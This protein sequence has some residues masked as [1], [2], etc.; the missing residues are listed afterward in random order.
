MDN[1]KI[2]MYEELQDLVHAT[3]ALVFFLLPYSPDLN[4]IEVGVSLLKRWIQRY[5]NMAFREVPLG[6]LKVAM[7]QC[8]R[9]KELVGENLYSHCGYQVNDLVF[10]EA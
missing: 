10:K 3:G 4:P 2:H 8:T 5:A 7:H 1:A 6:V 9:Q